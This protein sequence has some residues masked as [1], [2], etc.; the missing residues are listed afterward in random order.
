[1]LPRFVMVD[2]GK[3]HGLVIDT[4]SHAEVDVGE[5]GVRV[6]DIHETAPGRFGATVEGVVL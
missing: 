1:V 6:T 3:D 4:R 5:G 2:P